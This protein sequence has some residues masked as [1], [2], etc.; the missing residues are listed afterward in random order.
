[1]TLADEVPAP[2]VAVGCRMT[3]DPLHFPAVTRDD[4]LAAPVAHSSNSGT[5]HCVEP[6]LA[7]HGSVC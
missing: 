3:A 1:M 5:L 4:D 2:A 7:E 6:E